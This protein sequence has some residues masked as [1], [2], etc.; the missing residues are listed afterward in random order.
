MS[1]DQGPSGRAGPIGEVVRDDKRQYEIAGR[2][3]LVAA[4]NQAVNL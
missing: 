2:N 4:A 3:N 1:A